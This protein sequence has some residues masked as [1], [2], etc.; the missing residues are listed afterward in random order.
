MLVKDEGRIGRVAIEPLM[1]VHLFCDIGGTGAKSD[2]FT[3]WA[4][5]FIGKEIRCLKYYEA[6]GQDIATHLAWMRENGYT[7]GRARVVLPHDGKTNDRI[8]AVS[9]ESAFKSAGYEVEVIPNQGRGAAMARVEEAR[10]LFA[11]VWF[12][13]ENCQGG[14]DALGWYHEK[15][16]E[17]RNIGLGPEHD[18]ASHGADS[19]GLMC[20]AYKPP[21]KN[22]PKPLKFESWG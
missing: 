4:V 1:T 21:V 22:K 3:I 10:R 14:L 17:V 16:D 9:Y 8:Y 20:V 5:Q 6:V 18:W 2:A 12:D 13:E 7:P 15:K 11:S 19:F